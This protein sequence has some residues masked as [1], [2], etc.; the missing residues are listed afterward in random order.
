MNVVLQKNIVNGKEFD[1]EYK[2]KLNNK[3]KETL[4]KVFGDS[5]K[6]LTKKKKEWEILQQKEPTY[7]DIL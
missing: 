4:L 5:R 1:K 6:Q 3:I 7:A 2:I